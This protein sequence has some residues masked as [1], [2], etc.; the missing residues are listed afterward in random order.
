[1]D[2][3]AELTIP[4]KIAEEVIKYANDEGQLT[5]DFY[6]LR[7]DDWVKLDKKPNMEQDFR[8]RQSDEAHT[9]NRSG[10]LHIIPDF[11]ET[12][13][14]DA[15]HTSL[16]RKML[17][18]PLDKKTA[19][20]YA[21]TVN[22]KIKKEAKK[23][24]F[25][26]EDPT[27]PVSQVRDIVMSCAHL[28]HAISKLEVMPNKG[29]GLRDEDGKPLPDYNAI[30]NTWTNTFNDMMD[31]K[32]YPPSWKG[33]LLEAIPTLASR[34]GVDQPF[35]SEEI[36]EVSSQHGKSRTKCN[37]EELFKGREQ[38]S[39]VLAI[40]GAVSVEDK[41][42][43]MAV[44]QDTSAVLGKRKTPSGLPGRQVKRIEAA[45]DEPSANSQANMPALD[46]D[47]PMSEAETSNI[48]QANPAPHDQDISMAEVGS[49]QHDTS[50]NANSRE[51]KGLGVVKVK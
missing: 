30:F 19:D 49:T 18:D 5:E 51:V 50:S 48:H 40:K 28:H 38:A 21:K 15:E 32:G 22:P 26:G 37:M 20:E 14:N 9:E 10:H 6:E 23:Q 1:M 12:I 24:K 31:N 41:E 29:A 35:T 3:D 42:S 36:Q 34:R 13:C 11:V 17:A 43:S 25:E 27:L 39:K 2:E 46:A 16:F 8:E 4:P 33:Y 47:T 44:D 45:M 7:G